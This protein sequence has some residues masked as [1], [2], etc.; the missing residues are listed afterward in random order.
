MNIDC[1]TDVLQKI[2]LCS[3]LRLSGI[4]FVIGA[5]SSGHCVVVDDAH[6]KVLRSAVSNHRDKLTMCLGVIAAAD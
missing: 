6:I 3:T 2:V 1:G 5:S 4:P